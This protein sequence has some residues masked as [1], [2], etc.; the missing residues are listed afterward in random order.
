MD[1]QGNGSAGAQGAPGAVAELLMAGTELA[2]VLERLIRRRAGIGLV[3]FNV[4]RLL[5]SRE[6]EAAQ[7]SDLT[8]ALRM[9]SAHATTVLQQ[10]EQRGLVERSASPS[11]RRRRLVRLTSAGRAALDEALPALALLEDRLLAA[12]GSAEASA[13]L[14]GQLRRVRLV[15]REA[16]AADDLD[17]VGP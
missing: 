13:E 3:H 6:P 1:F 2:Q 9:S 7:P 11:D 17:C 10:L 12:L 16:L 8:R 14:W 15:M 4:L 5:G